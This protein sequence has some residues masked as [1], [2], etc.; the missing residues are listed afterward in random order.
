MTVRAQNSK[1]SDIVSHKQCLLAAMASL[2]FARVAKEPIQ[3]KVLDASST[4]ATW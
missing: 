2:A 1:T 3:P 4:C